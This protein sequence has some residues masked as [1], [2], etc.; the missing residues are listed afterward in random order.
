MTY[1]HI[2]TIVGL[3]IAVYVAVAVIRALENN[4]SNWKRLDRIERM[5]GELTKKDGDKDTD[6]D[7]P[8]K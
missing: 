3:G 7:K 5:L 2:W 6:K 8:E 1:D 4:A